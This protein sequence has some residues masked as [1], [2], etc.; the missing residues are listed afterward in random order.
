[1]IK[2]FKVASVAL[3]ST[4]LFSCS[5][6]E[7]NRDLAKYGFEY[8]SGFYALN[9]ATFQDENVED[10]VTPSN[11]SIVLSNVDLTNFDVVSNITKLKFDFPGIILEE[12]TFTAFTNYSLQIEGSYTRNTADEDYTFNDGTFLLNSAIS[13]LN[14]TEATLTIHNVGEDTIDLTFSFTRADGQIIS[15]KYIG[16]YTDTSV[17][18][19]TDPEPEEPQP[20]P[21]TIKN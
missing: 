17:A 5:D 7:A 13:G 9:T 21:K 14:A 20:E 16:L 6:D 12:G 4:I 2:L 15:G 1:M 3:F 8:N 18:P 19:V 10:E 11:L